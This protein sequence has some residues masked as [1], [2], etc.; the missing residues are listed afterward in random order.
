MHC[1]STQ[2][3]RVYAA[4]AACV[5]SAQ[6]SADCAPLWYAAQRVQHTVLHTVSFAATSLKPSLQIPVQQLSLHSRGSD[7]LQAVDCVTGM[8][9]VNTSV[10]ASGQRLK[11]V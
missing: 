10:P 3:L 6:Q 2:V 1:R 8:S 4:L 11:R 5:S 9:H 7:R